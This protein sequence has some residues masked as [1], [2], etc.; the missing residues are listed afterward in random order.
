MQVAQ[1]VLF[2]DKEHKDLDDKVIFYHL[3]KRIPTQEFFITLLKRW[4]YE[5]EKEVTNAQVWFLVQ[6]L[7]ELFCTLQNKQS[8]KVIFLCLCS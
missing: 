7:R 8:E 6:R 4:Y 2:L 1:L 5:R 3:V